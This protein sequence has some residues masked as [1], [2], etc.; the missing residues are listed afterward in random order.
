MSN[1]RTLKVVE[2]ETKQEPAGTALQ[3]AEASVAP[4]DQG[5]PAAPPALAPA[6]QAAGIPSE[7]QDHAL[8]LMSDTIQP[9][10]DRFKSWSENISTEINARS[11]KYDAD[12]AKKVAEFEAQLSREDA[13]NDEEI[14][15]LRS[16]QDNVGI[17]FKVLTDAVTTY[18]DLVKPV[19]RNLREAADEEQDE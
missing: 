2:D 14:A 6:H 16:L 4:E 11:A 15:G 3:T 18:T 8:N 7:H 1:M 10:L 13:A 19:G 5:E 12:R 9:Q 17:G